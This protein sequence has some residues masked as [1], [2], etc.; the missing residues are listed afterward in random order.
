M[1]CNRLFCFVAVSICL[2]L[3]GWTPPTAQ[4]ETSGPGSPIATPTAPATQPA[5]LIS[6]DAR[7]MLDAVDAAYGKLKSLHLAGTMSQDIRV[8][9]RSLQRTAAFTSSFLAPNLFRHEVKGN[10]LC[11]STGEKAFSYNERMRLFAMGDAPKGRTAIDKLPPPIPQFLDPSLMLTIAEVPSASLLK[12][13]TQVSKGDDV[14]IDGVSCPALVVKQK[15][16][17]IL[18]VLFDPQTHLMH[19]ALTDARALLVAKGNVNVQS[20]LLTVDYTTIAADADLKS[21]QFAWAPPEGARDAAAEAPQGAAAD[22]TALEGKDAPDFKLSGLDDKAVSLADVKGSVTILDFWAT[23][24][25]PCRASLP[26]LADLYA[27]MKGD[28]LKVYAVNCSEDKPTV[29]AF[30]EQT[31][32]A[33]PVLLDTDGAVSQKFDANAIPETVLIGKDG[34]V[35]KVFIGFSSDTEDQ[36]AAAVKAALAE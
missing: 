34:R 8:N 18:T 28:G 3:I 10:L 12:D 35:R 20:G 30:V 21:E 19:R 33:V 14:I 31:K 1:L 23:W 6:S 25:G 2:A 24:C 5:V 27:K 13:A 29:Q 32:L 17:T 22:A 16:G 36:I 15:P 7:T 26:H 4:A 9:G 11:G